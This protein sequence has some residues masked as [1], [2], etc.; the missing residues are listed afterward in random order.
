[1]KKKV[2]F[3]IFLQEINLTASLAPAA[4]IICH[5][6]SFSKKELLIMLAIYA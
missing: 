3:T 5:I 2:A 6:L 4:I 1:M